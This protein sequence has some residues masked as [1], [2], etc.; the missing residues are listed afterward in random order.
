MQEKIDL[1]WDQVIN[2][3][4]LLTWEEASRETHIKMATVEGRPAQY[5]ISLK[6]LREVM[7]LRGHEA[8]EQIRHYGGVHQICN[9][10]YTSPTEGKYAIRKSPTFYCFC[11]WKVMQ[12]VGIITNPTE[13]V[14]FSFQVGYGIN[15]TINRTDMWN[16]FRMPRVSFVLTKAYFHSGLFFF[17]SPST[18]ASGSIRICVKCELEL[19]QG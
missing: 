14:L 3:C 4:K 9:K 7:E 5:G 10:L 16:I 18:K 1:I 6:Q 12:M 13:A 8:V 11:V 15:V 19:F 17:R 2:V